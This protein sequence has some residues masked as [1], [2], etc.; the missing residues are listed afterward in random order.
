MY[1][2]D[3]KGECQGNRDKCN[4][5]EC[6]KFGLLNRPSRDGK[7]RVRGCNDPT[8]RGKRNR[9]KG[10]AKARHARHKLGLSATGNAGSRHEEHWSG[11]FR[12]EVK[13]GAQVG[14]IETR[15]RL[16]K[17]QSDISKA[18]GDIRPFAMIAMPEGNS[19]G[20]VL[21]T[22]NEFAEL[23]SLIKDVTTT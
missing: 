4:I 20:I 12:V 18:L 14:P 10:D 23:I 7:R 3:R 13:A 8:A 15:F 21:M 17:Q 16:A 19:D 1:E 11:I 2:H 9:A 22:L 6:P 5:P